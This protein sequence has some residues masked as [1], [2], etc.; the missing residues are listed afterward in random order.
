MLTQGNQ[1]EIGPPQMLTM[2]GKQGPPLQGCAIL[3]CSDLRKKK[4]IQ[5]FAGKSYYKNYA[6]HLSIK[7]IYLLTLL[8]FKGSTALKNTMPNP[9]SNFNF[10]IYWDSN[11][12]CGLQQMC[13]ELDEHRHGKLMPKD[14]F[15]YCLD[16]CHGLPLSWSLALLLVQMEWMLY[17]QVLQILAS[18]RAMLN[19]E[20][21][22][23]LWFEENTAC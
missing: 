3:N 1:S 23:S 19:L 13:L 18:K 22:V 6:K 12:E 9:P 17:Q 16:L 15:I 5:H 7:Y 2:L 11:T 8:L 14:S 10:L 21:G 20:F 4:N